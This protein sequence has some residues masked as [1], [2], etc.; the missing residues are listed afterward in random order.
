M[1]SNN[2]KRQVARANFVGHWVIISLIAGQSF[3][4]H[5]P[6]LANPD[7]PTLMGHVSFQGG[8]LPP[9]IVTVNRNPEFCGETIS[10][11]SIEVD[12]ET[13]G[14]S[15]AVVSIEGISSQKEFQD[16]KKKTVTLTNKECRFTP[17]VIT[18]TK[19]DWVE[20]VNQDP[21]LHNTHIRRNK[22]TFLNV[23]QT[24]EGNPVKKELKLAGEYE[25]QCDKHTFMK[26]NILTFDHPYFA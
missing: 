7:G 25:A 21:I 2:L 13:Y 26:A 17:R 10:L 22:R 16:S 3:L 6:G 5:S 14:L 9:E 11:E 23:A 24:P 1:T 4:F 19:G 15:D 20:I 8:I 12:I 18:A